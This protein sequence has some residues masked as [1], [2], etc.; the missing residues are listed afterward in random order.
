[1]L[2][3]E[4]AQRLVQVNRVGPGGAGPWISFPTYE[5]LRG[6]AGFDGML[7]TNGASRWTVTVG[8]EPAEQTSVE[9]GSANSF[10]CSGSSR[11]SGR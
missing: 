7:A 3:V 10:Q 5:A 6:S 11:C 8:A 4:E 2:P 1:M 9:L